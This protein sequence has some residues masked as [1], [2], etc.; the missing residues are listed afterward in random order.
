M[1]EN[2]K[3]VTIDAEDGFEVLKT[4]ANALEEIKEDLVNN[5]KLSERTRRELKLL[6]VG[7]SVYAHLHPEVSQFPKMLDILNEEELEKLSQM[8][9]ELDKFLEAKYEQLSNTDEEDLK[10][11]EEEAEAYKEAVKQL[12]KDSA[13]AFADALKKVEDL[14]IKEEAAE[15]ENG[16]DK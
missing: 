1:E 4:L 15:A 3:T 6:D 14:V 11:A 7:S 10:V 12:E 13:D 9:T 2:I 8:L 5:T 16:E